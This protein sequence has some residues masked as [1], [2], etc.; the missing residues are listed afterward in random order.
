MSYLRTTV[1]NKLNGN[2]RKIAP[3]FV[4]SPSSTDEEET[5][6]VVELA[7]GH[8]VRKKNDGGARSANFSINSLLVNLS[9]AEATYCPMCCAAEPVP[10]KGLG[11]K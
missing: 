6:D 1:I 8:I 4:A 10:E 9:I 2:D 5:D 7:C 3:L 11:R